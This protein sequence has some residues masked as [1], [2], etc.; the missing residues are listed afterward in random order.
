MF[1]RLQLSDP[2]KKRETAAVRI[3]RG[4]AKADVL[5]GTTGNDLIQGLGGNDVLR[6]S[7]GPD[8]LFGGDGS[9]TLAGGFGNDTLV[10]DAGIDTADYSM[11]KSDLQVF[12]STTLLAKHLADEPWRK[13]VDTKEFQAVAP[14]P[15]DVGRD[16]LIGIEVF[17]SGSGDDIIDA[18]GV[19]N[20]VVYGGQGDD[21]VMS[22]D[23]AY[24][25]GGA[26]KDELTA[27]SGGELYGG[28]GDDF[29]IVVDQPARLFGGAG[30]DTAFVAE[31]ALTGKTLTLGTATGA[32]SFIDIESI[33][34]LSVGVRII[35]SERDERFMLAAGPDSDQ[36]GSGTITG[37]GGRDTF[38]IGFDVEET[39]SRIVITDFQDG[40]DRIG[41]RLLDGD[42][43]RDYNWSTT[44][45]SGGTLV[46]VVGP[47]DIA[48]TL[49]LQ[50]IAAARI[51][52]ADFITF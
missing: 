18:T 5:F 29:L 1:R 40:I 4:T 39:T 32:L 33:E 28:G 50:K 16:M 41:V 25:F 44:Q 19:A 35:G 34:V 36:A 10:G 47:D 2:T 51:T 37:G 24:L 52:A 42:D 27:G 8:L 3:R 30:F 48:G 6:G 46:T 23:R 14:A 26:G 21:I 38:A 11:S 7:T 22:G 9:D 43:L 17:V 20:A 31:S 45:Q 15:P 12:L 49:F 13:S